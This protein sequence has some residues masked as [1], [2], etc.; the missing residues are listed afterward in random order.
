MHTYGIDTL[1]NVCYKYRR[2][3]MAVTK[4]FYSVS[5]I[6]NIAMYLSKRQTKEFI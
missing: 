6:L 1:V 4:T 2:E 5:G 3:T